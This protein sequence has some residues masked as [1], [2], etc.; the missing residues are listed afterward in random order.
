[1]T[2][3]Y[4]T[5]E[6]QV[7]EAGYIYPECQWIYDLELSPDVIPKPKDGEAEAF[8][9]KTVDEVK[10]DLRQGRFKDNC[11]LVAINFL[12]RR[13]MLKEEGQGELAEIRRRMNRVIP[14][15]GPHQ[16]DW[17]R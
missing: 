4:I 9:L 11:A 2:Y 13:G 7:G 10:E 16:K 8:Y 1:M 6:A 14:F 12:E 17:K 15:P 3:I 5:N